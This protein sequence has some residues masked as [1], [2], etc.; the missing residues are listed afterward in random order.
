MPL[1]H[2]TSSIMHSEHS[3]TVSLAD[4]EKKVD[5]QYTETVPNVQ[6]SGSTSGSG[7]K[8]A[9]LEILGTEAT[10]LYITPEEERAVLRK[11]DLWLM[12]VIVMVYFL[13]Q[14]DKYVP[15]SANSE[16][17][18]ADDAIGHPYRIHRCS[19]SLPMRV[20]LSF[21]VLFH[22][23]KIRGQTSS[24]PSIAGSVALSMLHR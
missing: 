12:P 1:R 10:P 2:P 17:T 14:L 20:S 22:L 21:K 24:E 16:Q 3:P 9:A 18:G 15:N 13:Q 8:D 6:A 7:G 11:I 4:I 5:V 23:L 19:G